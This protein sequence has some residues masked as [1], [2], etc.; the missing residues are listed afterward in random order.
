MPPFAAP[1]AAIY[2]QGSVYAHQGVPHP[3]VSDS[4]FINYTN[5]LRV[6]CSANLY[7]PNIS[8]SS[9]FLAR[10]I[11]FIIPSMVPDELLA[12]LLDNVIY[13]LYVEHQIA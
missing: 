9:F 5:S 3:V 8:L 10:Y 12:A 2:S 4:V 6:N 11:R 1:Y 13:I 7:G